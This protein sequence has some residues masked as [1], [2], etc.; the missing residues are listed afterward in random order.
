MHGVEREKG[1]IDIS[2]MK[3]AIPYSTQCLIEYIG[4]ESFGVSASGGSD[5]VSIRDSISTPLFRAEFVPFFG[6]TEPISEHLNLRFNQCYS[7]TEG[8]PFTR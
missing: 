7:S 5:V 8:R 2:R 4:R 6:G 3:S 1:E